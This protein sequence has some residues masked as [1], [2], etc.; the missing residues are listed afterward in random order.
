MSQLNRVSRARIFF[1]F[2]FFEVLRSL[3]GNS[4]IYSLS[5]IIQP[6]IS[7]ARLSRQRVFLGFE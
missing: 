4:F 7:Y 3:K 2:S 5:D 1:F 6:G